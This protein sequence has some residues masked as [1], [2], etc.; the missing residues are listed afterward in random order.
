MD[1]TVHEILQART[2]EWVAF[3]FPGDLPNPGI[4]ARSPVLQAD[5]LSAEPPGKLLPL[6]GNIPGE[7]ITIV[8]P[9]I[10]AF[11]S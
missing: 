7:I 1:Y 6:Q 8:L 9:N 5:S 10:L 11:S 2:L 3:P 4:K